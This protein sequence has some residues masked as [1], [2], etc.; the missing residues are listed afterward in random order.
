[1]EFE[2]NA[3]F[4]DIIEMG[5]STETKAEKV[6]KIDQESPVAAEVEVSSK[7]PAQAHISAIGNVSTETL[8]VEASNQ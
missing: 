5:S 2:N 3:L 7:S 4:S 6:E 1:L 8:V